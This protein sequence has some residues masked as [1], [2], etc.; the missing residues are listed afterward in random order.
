MMRL[1]LEQVAQGCVQPLGWPKQDS[2]RHAYPNSFPL[3]VIPLL[4]KE[5]ST[6]RLE[7]KWG[8]SS[9]LALLVLNYLQHAQR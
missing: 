1:L 7:S 4:P 5:G 6:P 3:G 2:I 8:E 9:G